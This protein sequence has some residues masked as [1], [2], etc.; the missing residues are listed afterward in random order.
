[1][2]WFSDDSITKAGDLAQLVGLRRQNFIVRLK[3]DAELH[4]HR[5]VIYHN[6]LI[7]IPWGSYFTSR[8][9]SPFYIL[10]PG[11]SD[12]LRTIPRT[13]QIMY[14]KDIGYILSYMGIGPGMTVL[15]AGTGSGALTIAL[16]FATGEH[17]Q[18]I[19]YDKGQDCQ[20]LAR[21]NLERVGLSDRVIFKNQDIE[22]GFSETN[23]PV[24]YLDVQHPYD[25]LHHV[26][27]ALKPGGFFGCIVPTANQV[28]RCLSAL[29]REGFGFIEVCDIMLRFYKADFEHFRPTD[30]MV[31]HTG[32]LMFAALFIFLT[33]LLHFNLFRTKTELFYG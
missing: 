12:L 28:I 11:L 1:M 29:K 3:A 5:G 25:Y 16:A 9:G 10:Q 15:E 33:S 19:S 32:Y 20:A 30:R 13:T 27:A 21:K 22:Q 6:E 24:V 7:G 23:L 26:K 2:T 14:P 8:N 18:V 4:T 17:G 31:S